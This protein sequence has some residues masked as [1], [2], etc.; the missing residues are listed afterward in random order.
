MHYSLCSWVGAGTDADPYRPAGTDGVAGWSCVDLRHDASTSQGWALVASPS[1]LPLL[2]AV[3][4]TLLGQVYA[5]AASEDEPLSR[6]E[7]RRAE[8]LLGVQLASDVTTMRALL[9]HL[10]IAQAA[11]LLGRW[12]RVR[13]THRGRLETHLGGMHFSMPEAQALQLTESFTGPDGNVGPDNTDQDW[14][15]LNGSSGSDWF[16]QSNRVTGS[17]ASYTF[18]RVETAFS[19]NHFSE[20]DLGQQSGD[21]TNRLTGV[22]VRFPASGTAQTCYGLQ[23]NVNST[24]YSL[25]KWVNG[26]LTVLRSPAQHGQP[27]GLVRM[28]LEADGSTLRMY[29]NGILLATITD[30]SLGT[31]NTKVGLHSGTMGSGLAWIDDW[32]GGD[33]GPPE[34]VVTASLSPAGLAIRRPQRTVAGSSRPAATWAYTKT[35]YR[36][37]SGAVALTGLIRRAHPRI[38][39]GGFTGS[40]LLFSK[41]AVRPQLI[42]GGYYLR[43]TGLVRRAPVRVFRATITASGT[44]V[45]TALGRLFGRPG[46]VSVTV[47]PTAD[48][49]VR[50]RRAR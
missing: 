23:A 49:R 15:E 16:V 41:L 32:Q 24:N 30:T 48:V 3:V 8:Q 4:G 10:L 7:L 18:M 17:G 40:R 20:A 42:K 39:T 27:G 44:A 13:A 31:T 19:G 26:T 37:V 22:A 5:V 34:K 14:I 6:T 33:L 28:R 45:A 21:T 25:R 47:R 38:L 36:L 50:F 46:T 11:P 9:P 12:D 2:T 43:P 1:P 29:A 35:A